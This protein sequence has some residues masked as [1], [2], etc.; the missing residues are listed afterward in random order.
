M[1]AGEPC[2]IYDTN[3]SNTSKFLSKHIWWKIISFLPEGGLII[4]LI[5][6]NRKS[7][8]ED[9]NWIKL[10]ETGDLAYFRKMFSFENDVITIFLRGRMYYQLPGSLTMS[11]HRL[12]IK[13]IGDVPARII[14]RVDIRGDVVLENLSFKK[15]LRAT[16]SQVEIFNCTFANSKYGLGVCANN[17][18]LLLKS[19]NFCG[20]K[21]PMSLGGSTIR[22]ED[23][24]YVGNGE[25]VTSILNNEKS[26]LVFNGC[27]VYQTGVPIASLTDTH[28]V[29]VLDEVDHDYD[30]SG[31]RRSYRIYV[32]EQ[33][34]AINSIGDNYLFFIVPKEVVRDNDYLK[35]DCP[36]GF[37]FILDT[38]CLGLDWPD[39]IYQCVQDVINFS[40]S[41]MTKR[42][43]RR[44]I[45]C[46]CQNWDI[47]H[48][49]ISEMRVYNWYDL[50]KCY[51]DNVCKR[52]PGDFYH[53]WNLVKE[54]IVTYVFTHAGYDVNDGVINF[55]QRI[56]I[57][58]MTPHLNEF[59]YVPI[60]IKQFGNVSRQRK[61]KKK[62][63]LWKRRIGRKSSRQK[64][65][66]ISR[67]KGRKTS[68]QNR[69]ISSMKTP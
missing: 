53:K 13:G 3:V 36:E 54:G 56:H 49:R 18:N 41:S 35:L 38:S 12:V 64:G 26:T 40:A 11:D 57:H 50:V 65:K 68:R 21:Y 4:S 34:R 46:I 17:T 9:P 14:N 27:R 2:T 58:H 7:F 5:Q 63:D 16:E 66:K 32:Y 51:M 30:P 25:V 23:C 22:F 43:F 39:E 33:H 69:K 59:S 48:V 55:S 67:Q 62:N 15:G 20:L 24:D 42:L 44:I 19:T 47:S 45:T 29:K 6:L 37:I 31:R 28:T 61:E 8:R 1:A 52:Q 10:D 60:E